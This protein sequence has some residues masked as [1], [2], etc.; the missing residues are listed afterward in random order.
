MDIT[1][2]S[3][4]ILKNVFNVQGIQNLYNDK[5]SCFLLGVPK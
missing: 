3:M 4:M 1:I 2:R 5:R